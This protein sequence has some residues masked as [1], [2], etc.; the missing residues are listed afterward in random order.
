M[1]ISRMVLS[2]KIFSR[3]AFSRVTF[4]IPKLTKLVRLK[5]LLFYLLSR[6]ILLGATTH[7]IT[8]FC[9]TKCSITTFSITMN[10]I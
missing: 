10:K 7:S 3:L 8:T 2:M 9:I 5:D 6:V 4:S 1:T